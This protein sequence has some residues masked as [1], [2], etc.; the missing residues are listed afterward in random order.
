MSARKSVKV[1][2]NKRKSSAWA[3]WKNGALLLLNIAF[4]SW[5]QLPVKMVLVDIQACA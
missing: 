2:L 4:K 5:L 1:R 3:K